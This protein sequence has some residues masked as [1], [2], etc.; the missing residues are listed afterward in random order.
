MKFWNQSNFVSK[1][2]KLYDLLVNKINCRFIWRCHENNIH[3]NYNKCIS[4]NHLEIGPGTGYFIEKYKFNKLLINDINKNIL[5]YSSLYLK[6]H[7]PK[8]IQCN[9]FNQKLNVKNINSI[10]INYVLHCVPGKLEDK[11]F[12]LINNLEYKNKLCLFGATVINDPEYNNIFSKYMIFWLNYMNI[13]NN[14]NDYSYNLVK[15]C[16][17]NNLNI[18]WKIIG[19]VMIFK[20][21]F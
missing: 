5:Q 7:N 13:F 6:T 21:R 2:M 4:K 1:N 8:L 19:C 3:Q 18:E 10:G 16:E 9:L 11:L 12:K 20:I 17:A 14:K 15:K